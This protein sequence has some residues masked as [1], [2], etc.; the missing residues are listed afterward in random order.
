MEITEIRI[1]PFKRKVHNTIAVAQVSLDNELL[2]TGLELCERNGKYYIRYP[3][4]NN[5]KHK[6]CYCQPK[7][8]TFTDYMLNKILEKYDE[9]KNSSFD[10][11]AVKQVMEQWDHDYTNA[12]V[13]MANNVDPDRVLPIDDMDNENEET[14][15]D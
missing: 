8:R 15:A 11:H 5:N 4:N 3:K 2:I 13:D 10:I 14:Q 12:I 9:R 6:L 1:Y 7:T